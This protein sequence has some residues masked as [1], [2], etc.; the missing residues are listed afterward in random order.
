MNDY[1]DREQAVKALLGKHWA[2]AEK[3]IMRDAILL[4]PAADVAPVK[5]ATW[6][7]LEYDGYADGTPVYFVWECS[8]CGEEHRGEENT[9]TRF[10]PNCGAKMDLEETP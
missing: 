1:I 7:G 8:N 2:Y 3:E 10:C 6:R 4:V 9:L 5:H